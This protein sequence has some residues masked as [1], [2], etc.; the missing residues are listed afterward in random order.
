MTRRLVPVLTALA[1][2]TAV[3][4]LALPASA[5]PAPTQV[6]GRRA[7]TY[8]SYPTDPTP[9]SKWVSSSQ[10][11][12]VD[13]NGNGI[14]D[15][16]QGRGA[17]L[18]TYGIIRYREDYVRLRVLRGGVWVTRL[19]RE[20][21]VVR[22]QPTAYATILTPTALVCRTDPSLTD[23]YSVVHSV[24]FRRSD[25]VVGRRTLVS[26]TFTA[27]L[28]A[29]DPACPETPPPPPAASAD[30]EVTVPTINPPSPLHNESFTAAVRVVN[31]G[32]S[33]AA[34]VAVTIDTDDR[35]AG[36]TADIP[37]GTCTNTDLNPDPAA[38]N[39]GIVCTLGTLD[40]GEVAL[41]SVHGTATTPGTYTVTATTTSTSSYADTDTTTV[42]F[43]VRAT[44]DLALDKALASADT[45]PASGSTVSYTLTVHN[46]GLD[47][48]TSTTVVD[49][50]PGP[51]GA[52]TVAPGGDATCALDATDNLVCEF[53]SVLVD[54][55]ETVTVSS[56][57]TAAPDTSVTNTAAVSSAVTDPDTSDNTDSVTVVVAAS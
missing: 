45:T 20:T 42:S 53:G 7:V 36:R 57:I 30:L 52:V 18:E 49:D 12:F 46:A 56:T 15:S 48:A 40:S 13:T 41:I 29:S 8:T 28:L 26:N 14:R 9:T 16:L 51:L 31:N 19:A 55:T 50:W 44:A 21:D 43:V 11:Q 5:A 33:P 47:T 35:I 2:L 54:A 22:E 27:R 39:E 6:L 10:G 4:A 24:L 17:D 23:T 38:V 37:G 34:G 32:P 3:I 25:E 1:T